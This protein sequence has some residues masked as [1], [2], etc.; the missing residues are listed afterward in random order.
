MNRNITGKPDGACFWNVLKY[1]KNTA[2]GGED[3]SK[4]FM[5]ISPYNQETCQTFSSFQAPHQP[6]YGQ[7]MFNHVQLGYGGY[8][9][10]GRL[11]YAKLIIQN[12]L[13][14]E[15]SC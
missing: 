15:V 2:A 13:E 6:C 11:P 9:W 7:L 3:G 1:V 5:T 12:W 10:P 14:L 4:K 8:G